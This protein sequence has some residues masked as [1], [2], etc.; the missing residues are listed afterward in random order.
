MVAAYARSD[1]FAT[2]LDGAVGGLVRGLL[3]PPSRKTP[4]ADA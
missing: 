4:G 1:L 2:Q 3:T